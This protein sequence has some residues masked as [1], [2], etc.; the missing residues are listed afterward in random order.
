MAEMFRNKLFLIK[1]THTI[2]F[3]FMS[4]CLI[5]VLY[6][7]ITRTYNWTLLVALSAILIEGLA[8]LIN[9]GR[10]PLTTLAEKKGAVKG[11]VT[12]IFLPQFIARNTFKFSSVLFI[13]ELIILVAGYAMK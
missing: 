9:R 4:A 2:I 12:D 1:L 7:G 3:F 10:C 6:C 11:S 5:Y 13:V 8:L